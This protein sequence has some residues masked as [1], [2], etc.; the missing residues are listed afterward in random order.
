LTRFHRF[1][2]GCYTEFVRRFSARVRRWAVALLIG[3]GG[4]G[5]AP[6]SGV[7]AQQ[8]SPAASVPDVPAVRIDAVV[9]DAKG[10]PVINLRSA[11]FELVEN[12]A[13][14]P[15]ASVELRTLPA[16]SPEASPI[17]SEA[18][19]ERAARQPGT[20]VFAIFLD[21]FHVTAGPS[22]DRL[23]AALHRFVDEQLRPQDL[24]IVMKPLDPITSIR[25]TRDRAPL[26]AAIDS[27]A[28]RKGEFAA[29]TRFEELY[30]GRAPATVAAARR[31]IVTAG[32]RELTMRM[33]ELQADRGVM[34]LVSEGFPRDT[35]PS[36]RPSRLVDLQGV[37]RA[38]SRY[39]IA[40]YT[41][42][43]TLPDEDTSPASD[44][45][46]AAAT[47]QWLAAQT[48]GRATLDAQALAPGFA[49]MSAD[50]AAYYVLT[51][52]P[53]QADGRFH[54]I[55]VRAKRRDAEVQVRPGY[56]AP[57]GSEWRTMVA[58]TSKIASPLSTRPLRKSNLIDTWLGLL[59]VP[60]ARTRM[61][62]TWEPRVRGLSA[63]EVVAL[64]AKTTDG[65][66]L[67]DGRIARVGSDGALPPDSAR[68]EVPT[69]RVELDMSIYDMEGKLIDT[70]VRDFDVPDLGAQKRGPVLLAP[71]VVRARTLR[72]F[73]SASS[74]PD[75]APASVR[76]F[77][78]ADR[79]LIRVPA[80]DTS[81]AAVKVTAKILNA[82]GQ[83]MRDIDAI[84]ATPRD[85]V[86]QFALPLSWLVPGQYQIELQGTNANGAVKERVSFKVSG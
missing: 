22:G 4:A 28:G 27:F 53:A 10:L 41:A 29:L 3:A 38:A 76:T 12:G 60:G 58:N 19:E 17:Q 6:R 56:W 84:D 77:A 33:G 31:Q 79:L 18:D 73:N 83:P 69:G 37:V 62:I 24:A 70:D 2:L 39:H 49:R 45:D 7:L 50:L 42:N 16:T 23:R 63:P 86:A 85:G 14:R 80:F 47:L 57:L 59:P 13:V 15:L 9:T 68:F 20:R 72:D 11:D 71:E 36:G 67:F 52:Q 74:N 5:L 81:G 30:I 75:A 32:L 1:A 26:H 25:F 34:L 61:V 35:T 64:H 40:M 46:R 54:P 82:W 21:E 51:Y 8:P 48:G 44:R 78:R 65:T 55:E 66:V 43:P